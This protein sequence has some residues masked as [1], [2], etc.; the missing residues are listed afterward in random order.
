MQL[1][2]TKTVLLSKLHDELLEAGAVIDRIEGKPDGTGLTCAEVYVH[3]PD[4][5]PQE[6]VSQ[7]ET[8]V[9]L[10]NPTPPPQPPTQEERLAALEEAVLEMILGKGGK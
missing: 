9:A 5:T 7:I 2:F 10:H 1:T 3:V 8:I 4:D 6:V